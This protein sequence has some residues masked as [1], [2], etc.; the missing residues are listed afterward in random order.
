MTNEKKYQLIYNG[1]EAYPLCDTK[2]EAEHFKKKAA[3][4]SPEIK[5]EIKEITNTETI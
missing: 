1:N 3:D 5:V 4:Q 2:E